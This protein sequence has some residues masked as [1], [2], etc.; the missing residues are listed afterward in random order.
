M[1]NG[2]VDEMME[3]LEWI[4]FEKSVSRSHSLN[5]LDKVAVKPFDIAN[6][7]VSNAVRDCLIVQSQSK[8][9]KNRV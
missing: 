5:E 1:V 8:G 2:V 9:H 7:V 6:L 3:G 4:N